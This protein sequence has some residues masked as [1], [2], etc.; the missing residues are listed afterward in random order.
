MWNSKLGMWNGE[1]AAPRG[2]MGKMW[3]SKLG[4]WNGEAAAPR[5]LKLIY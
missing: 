3:N 4:M 1:A 5:G 2:L